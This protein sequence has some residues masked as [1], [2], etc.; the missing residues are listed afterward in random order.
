MSRKFARRELDA[1]YAEMPTLDC[2]GKCAEACGPI[3]MS[4]VEWERIE[5]RG[6]VG[7]LGPDLTCPLLDG[8]RCSVYDIRPTICRLWGMVESMPCLWGCKPSRLLTD[9]EGGAFLERAGALGA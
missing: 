6:E 7:P 3:L 5:E 2:Q 9:D 8:E 4:R 1:M